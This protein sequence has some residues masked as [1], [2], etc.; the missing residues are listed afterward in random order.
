MYCGLNCI[1][2]TSSGL[3]RL[4]T[5][6]ED[7]SAY[8]LCTFAFSTGNVEDPVML[9]TGKT[10]VKAF[11]FLIPLTLRGAFKKVLLRHQNKHNLYVRPSCLKLQKK[12]INNIEN[13][14]LTG[15][16]IK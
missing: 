6:W 12:N 11:A 10:M 16:V 9:F 13:E 5:G 15:F 4:L 7:K 8:A 14:Q 1:S 2:N 3:H